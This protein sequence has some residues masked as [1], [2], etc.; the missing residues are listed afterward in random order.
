MTDR[1]EYRT[2]FAALADDPDA[3]ALSGDAFKLLIMLKL[4][5]PVTGIGVI[6]PSKLCDQVGV[7]RAR[8]D[9]CFAELLAAKPGRDRGWIRRD[10]NVV[11]IVKAFAHEPGMTPANKNHL[12]YIR[13]LV[14]PLDP[15]SQTVAEFRA[16]YRVWFHGDKKA[17]RKGSDIPSQNPSLTHPD[18]SGHASD[19]QAD[20]TR[21]DTQATKSGDLDPERD[22]TR[23]PSAPGPS[24]SDAAPRTAPLAGARSAELQIPRGAQ[25]FVRHFYPKN[26]ATRERRAD[27]ARQ[28]AGTLAGGTPLRRGQLVFAISPERLEAKCAEVIAQ[29]VDAP[30]KAIVVL[31]LKLNDTSDVTETAARAS[32]EA[33][34]QEEHVTDREL[35]AAD[36]WL[37][38]HPLIEQS[39]EAQLTQQ[40]YAAVGDADGFAQ[41][42]RRFAR[43]GLVL[44]A[45]RSAGAPEAAHV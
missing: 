20:T 14:A 13:K 16:V 26:R 3:H 34:A 15:S 17:I 41:V 1:G 11:W 38:E 10:R 2:L 39:L 33:R 35:A 32:A 9:A 19:T 29:G 37:A 31:L 8:L 12:K 42:C 5:L 36:A 25:E 30:D 7:D 21:H 40:G 45:W 4:S 27:I 28:L 43:T 24:S 6:Y 44:G 22:A 23:A 18:P